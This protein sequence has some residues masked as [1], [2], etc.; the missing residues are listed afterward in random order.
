MPPT[1]TF[2]AIF[3]TLAAA[4]SGDTTARITVGNDAAVEKI[5]TKLATAVNQLLER[6]E[7]SL[8]ELERTEKA[9]RESEERFAVT[10]HSSPVALAITGV[11]DGKYVE[12]NQQFCELLGYSRAELIGRSN[13]ELGILSAHEREA[14]AEATQRAG[15]ARNVEVRL[16][17]RDGS[18]RDILYSANMVT[19]QGADHFLIT[20]LDITELKR[21]QTELQRLATTDVLTNLFN[22][23]YFFELANTE[24]KRAIRYQQPL[25][26]VL[27]D[28]DHF[29]H[30]NDTFGHAAGDQVLTAFATA[31][32][33]NIR[34]I[35]VL[36]RFGGE[37]FILLMPQTDSEQAYQVV[38]R[39]RLATTQLRIEVEVQQISLTSSFG[40]A[41]LA[42]EQDTL[43]AILQRADEALYAAKQSGRNRV[44]IWQE[45]LASLHAR[46]SR[47]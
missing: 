6:A 2:D 18:L 20:M 1:P 21:A 13:V 7:V 29:K 41:V 14:H 43:D 32:K 37:E 8:T 42:G 10:F 26:L 17:V 45:S 23:R 28:L 16:H 44:T 22:R 30:I 9:L 27:L 34:E 25:A 4:T 36:A 47:R 15:W 11:L 38:E 33:E 31:C 39:L 35:D 24:L 40:L 19:L 3:A 46:Q 12:V 5:E